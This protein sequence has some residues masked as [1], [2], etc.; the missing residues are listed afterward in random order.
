MDGMSA[1][2]HW[3]PT[4]AGHG[5]LGSGAH[6]A[7]DIGNMVVGADGTGSLTFSSDEWEVRTGSG[8]DVLGHAVIVHGGV[9][10]FTSQ[11]AGNAG[12]RIACGVV[13]DAAR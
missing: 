4:G 5:H 7:G 12:M 6:H 9:D 13:V 2:G 1:G 8:S 11:P 10:D 3:N